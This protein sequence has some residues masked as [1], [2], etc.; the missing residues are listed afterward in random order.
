MRERQAGTASQSP[1]KAAVYL[2]RACVALVL[3]LVRRWPDQ[4]PEAA[5]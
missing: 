1:V 2:V 4:S 5:R 3:A